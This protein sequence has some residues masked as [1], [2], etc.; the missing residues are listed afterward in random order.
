MKKL[1]LI[2]LYFIPVMCYGIDLNLANSA[3]L[4]ALSGLTL[5]VESPSVAGINPASRQEGIS[6]SGSY[7]FNLEEI[8]I[9]SFQAGK[10]WKKFYITAGAENIANTLINS[11]NGNLSVNFRFKAVTW[12]LG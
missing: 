9:Y 3:E 1:R 7:L 11:W 8:P 5:M 10:S 12:G 4:N 2:F 6:L